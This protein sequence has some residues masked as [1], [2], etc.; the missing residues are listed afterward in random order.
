MPSWRQALKGG[1]S[2]YPPR[3]GQLCPLRREKQMVRTTGVVLPPATPSP[4]PASWKRAQKEAVV[5][6]DQ[7]PQLEW[8]GEWEPPGWGREALGRWGWGMKLP[9]PRTGQG[10]LECWALIE[11][12]WASL[13]LF[14]SAPHRQWCSPLGSAFHLQCIF[15]RTMTMLFR[16]KG[17]LGAAVSKA[18]IRIFLLWEGRLTS[19]SGSVQPAPRCCCWTFPSSRR[20]SGPLC[21]PRG[22]AQLWPRAA[23]ARQDCLLH[24][25]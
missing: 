1:F 15:L 18:R 11:L 19:P 8:F 23:L 3:P 13:K 17:P 6:S 4:S 21:P 5:M 2:S 7:W 24:P 14:L 12:P 10:G 20:W 9:A 22:P 25:Q 16:A